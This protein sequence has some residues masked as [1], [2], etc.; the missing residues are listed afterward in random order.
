[1]DTVCG[2]VD[3]VTFLENEIVHCEESDEVAGVGGRVLIGEAG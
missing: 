3:G 1:M 2:D